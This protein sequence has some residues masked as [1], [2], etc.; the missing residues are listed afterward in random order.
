MQLSAERLWRVIQVILVEP[1]KATR[2]GLIRQCTFVLTGC[3]Q[4]PR[5][6]L[7]KRFHRSLRLCH[8][9]PIEK[10]NEFH[11]AILVELPVDVVSV[12]SNFPA[13]LPYMLGVGRPRTRC[14][15]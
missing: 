10:V 5:M 3:D 6:L 9:A 1:E 11:V 7:H 12:H 15:C 4:L 14:S 13:F 8:H 2:E